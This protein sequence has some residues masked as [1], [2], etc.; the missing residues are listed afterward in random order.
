MEMM[1][2]RKAWL[3]LLFYLMLPWL[4]IRTACQARHTTGDER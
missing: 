3:I 2:I 4:L 1:M